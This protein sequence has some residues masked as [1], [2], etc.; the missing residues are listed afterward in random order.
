MQL[1]THEIDYIQK[2]ITL[3]K[4]VNIENV[5]LEP[6]KV[7]AMNNEQTIVLF[8]DKDVPDMQFG[9]LGLNRIN[10]F[11]SRLEVARSQDNFSITATTTGIDN[12]VGYDVYDPSSKLPVPMWIRSMIMSGKNIK[13]NFRSASPMTIK[14]PKVRASA[15]TFS[16]DL[17]PE[18]IN[19]IV[20]GKVAMKTDELTFHGSE[21]GA[22]LEMV[23][24]N[25]DAMEYQFAD[26]TH[27]N[28][29]AKIPEFSYKYP[30]DSLLKIFKP[31]PMGTFYI[32]ARGQLQYAVDGIDVYVMARL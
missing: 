22:V 26:S 23:D 31:N 29:L 32:T 11:T 9:S 18:L 30:I 2:I 6:G 19:M 1:L 15:P 24:I 20:K 10:D 25:G 14:A 4:S 27:I 3:A 7:R 17:N 16:V 12:N 13:I 28:Q 8:Q 21:D 5:I